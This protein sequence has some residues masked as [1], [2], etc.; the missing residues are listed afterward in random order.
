MRVKL[1]VHLSYR[2][3]RLHS[4]YFMEQCHFQ[5]EE[6]KWGQGLNLRRVRR[7]WEVHVGTGKRT[8][9]E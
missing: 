3:S 1:G 6:R 2:R 9:W 7:V 4:S 5:R 8:H